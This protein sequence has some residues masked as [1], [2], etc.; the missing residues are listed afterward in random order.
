MIRVMLV[1]D[2]ALF[3]KGL[4]SLIETAP[5]IEVC[6]ETPNVAS[7]VATYRTARPD[8][9]LMDMKL[10]DGEGL[11]ALNSILLDDPAAKVVMLSAFDFA[12]QV[13]ACMRA[14]ARGY[15]SKDLDPEELFR[16]IDTVHAGGVALDASRMTALLSSPRVDRKAEEEPLTP[17]ESEVA[18]LVAKGK[19]NRQ[20]AETLCVSPL[21]VKAHMASILSKLGLHGRVELAAWVL[22]RQGR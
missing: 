3:R 7:T 17:R 8:I 15:L 21:T 14:G 19:T 11:D 2:H 9:V 10:P 22:A 6:A 1:D 18:D 4:R 12:D 13:A 5:G 20:I 16:S